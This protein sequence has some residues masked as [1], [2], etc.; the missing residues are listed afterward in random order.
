MGGILVGA[1]D[2]ARGA[3]QI[4]RVVKSSADINGPAFRALLV[5][6]IAHQSIML[7]KLARTLEKTAEQA[8]V[9]LE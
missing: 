2:L 7:V 6:L 1:E 8:G 3:E 5:R 9:E 4:V